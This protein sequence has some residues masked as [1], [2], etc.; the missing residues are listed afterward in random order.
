MIMAKFCLTLSF[1]L[2]CVFTIGNSVVLLSLKVSVTAPHVSCFL[3]QIG[4]RFC[5]FNPAIWSLHTVVYLN[6]VWKKKFV[7]NQ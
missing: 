6:H 7:K 3:Q 4:D 2:V 1:V 5:Y